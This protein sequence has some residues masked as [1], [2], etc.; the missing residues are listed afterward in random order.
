MSLNA[1]EEPRLIRE[2]NIAMT[3]FSSM[4]RVGIEVRR[5]ALAERQL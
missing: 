4:R 1:V 3:L 2:S 5:S